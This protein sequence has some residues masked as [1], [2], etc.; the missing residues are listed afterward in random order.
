MQRVRNRKQVRCG[1]LCR[2]RRHAAARGCGRDD[3]GC[4]AVDRKCA[5][6]RTPRRC[7][8]PA[9]PPRL[10]RAI[11]LLLLASAFGVA[12]YFTYRVLI[13]DRP[14]ETAALD[15]AP[16][17]APAEMPK[18]ASPADERPA[19]PAAAPAPGTAVADASSAPQ[20]AGEPATAAAP[21]P[22]P[23]S[24]ADTVTATSESPAAGVPKADA[25]KARPPRPAA[26]STPK[27]SPKAGAAAPAAIAPPPASAAPA[28]VAAAPRPDRWELM[29]DELARCARDNVLSRLACEQ[30]VGIRY[31]DGYWGKVPQC[32]AGQ[33]NP[34]K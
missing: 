28:P 26:P 6:H 34:D 27:G 9:P 8:A 30:R 32:P 24:G 4:G 2:L 22:A 13:V 31:C 21:G 23:A 25:A 15:D 19:V 29:K 7:R 14:T 12:V 20:P 11:G 18:A 33:Q 1:I 3:A 10:V 16:R 5:G 17:A